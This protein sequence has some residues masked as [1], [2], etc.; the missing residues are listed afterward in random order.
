MGAT[1]VPDRV[2]AWLRFEPDGSVWIRTGKVELGQGIHAALEIVVADE[3]D[4]ELDRTRVAP[5]DT[6]T[7]R[8]EGVTA[9]SRSIEESGETLRRVAATARRALLAVAAARLH[10]GVDELRVEAGVISTP[11]GDSCTY[12]TL[13]VDGALRDLLVDP[14]ASPKPSAARRIIGSSPVRQDL[15]RKVTGASAFLQDL[16]LPGM[17]HGRIVRPPAPGSRLRSVDDAAIRSLPGVVALVRD[18]DF[19]GV[20]AERE[21]QAI[22]ALRRA[23]SAAH[24][25]DAPRLA[26]TSDPRY[27]LA[28]P[29]ETIV[30]RD[31]RDGPTPPRV[32]RTIEAEYTRPHIAHGSVGPSCA[33]ARFDSAGLE[34]WTHSQGIFRLRHE[35]A[36]VMGLSETNVR[37]HH[38]EGAGCYGHNGADD[39]ALDAALLARGRAGRPVRVQWMREDEFA[40]EPYGPAMLI[41][42]SADLAADG[43][44]IEWR[45]DLWSHGHET[46]PSQGGRPADQSALLAARHLARPFVVPLA[47]RPRAASSGG[48]RNAEPYYRFPRDRVVDHYVAESPLRVSALRSLG[49]HANVFAIESF[50]DELAAATGADPVELRLRHLDDVRARE[51]IGR[52]VAMAGP[53]PAHS[54]DGDLLRGRGLGF[55][56]YKN[57]AAYAAVVVDVELDTEIHVRRA[58]GAIDAG[59][60]ISRDG[61]ANQAEGG[62]VQ[63]VSW[64]LR[65]AVSTDASGVTSRD[66]DAYPTLRFPD[67]P[68]VE[69]DVIDRPD[70]PP[71]GAGEAMAGPTSAAVANAVAD[72]SGVRLRDLPLT[73]ERF[74]AAAG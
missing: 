48:R 18:G 31:R 6:A 28:L 11:A 66:W 52:A 32:A 50:V 7:S 68:A 25:S 39:V 67:A 13:V 30:V 59:M 17:L 35:L 49:A 60:V 44:I 55:A 38:R 27:L 1:V 36:L 41:R 57:S 22:A 63:A 58:W 2:D 12:A 16:E 62:I 42:L 69:I 21:E 72:A 51:V 26:A 5:V 10:V 46:R 43:S 40:W 56:R 20:I 3:L 9:G 65:E 61:L 37:V 54:G 14:E 23:G 29:A 24:W 74:I 71:V 73:R 8:D 45:H 4:V 34:V 19:L 47:G 70:V 15:L 53:R 33:V 64:T